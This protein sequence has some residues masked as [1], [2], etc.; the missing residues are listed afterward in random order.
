M[1]HI[2]DQYRQ[3]ENRLT[4]ELACSLA[5]DRW[6]LGRF[7]RWAL[8]EGPPAG[9]LVI[10]ERGLHGEPELDEEEDRRAR[11]RGEDRHRPPS[12]ARFGRHPHDP[13]APENGYSRERQGRFT[14]R[15]S[16]EH[17][18][19][20]LCGRPLRRAR[21]AEQRHV[22]RSRHGREGDGR[23]AVVGRT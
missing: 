7:L 12:A 10:T 17:G 21:S 20:H 23:S 19:L 13:T 5:E 18:G 6:L 14:R 9:R 1:R 11:C 8:D 2:L 22:W 4:H 3:P 15:V 16:L